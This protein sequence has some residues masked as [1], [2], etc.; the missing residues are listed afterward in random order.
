MILVVDTHALLC[1]ISCVLCCTA[2]TLHDVIHELGEVSRSDRDLLASEL[3]FTQVWQLGLVGLPAADPQVKV[4]VLVFEKSCVEG[5]DLLLLAKVI[6]ELGVVARHVSCVVAG[7]AVLVTEA[8]PCNRVLFAVNGIFNFLPNFYHF[9]RAFLNQ[10]SEKGWLESRNE[11]SVSEGLKV[12]A[13]LENSSGV[14]VEH[15]HLVVRELSI[16]LA[17]FLDTFAPQIV[18]HHEKRRTFS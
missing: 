5:R 15:T 12:S 4:S 17:D 16:L 13:V 11:L 7:V 9:R 14:S 6:D 18:K 10:T 1:G 3:M 2:H 8:D